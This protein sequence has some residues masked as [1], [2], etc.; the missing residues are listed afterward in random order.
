M[1]EVIGYRKRRDKAVQFE[2]LVNGIVDPVP[3]E[4][5]EMLEESL[6]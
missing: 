6:V 4:M 1:C 5:E 3:F 2:V